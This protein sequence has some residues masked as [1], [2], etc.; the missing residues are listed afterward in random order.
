MAYQLN[1][2]DEHPVI[3]ACCQNLKQ[4]RSQREVILWIGLA[5]EFADDVY[6]GRDD[7]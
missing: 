7:T 6:S 3:T 2:L 5:G 1:N 4:L